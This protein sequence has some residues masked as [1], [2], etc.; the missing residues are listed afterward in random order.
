MVSCSMGSK[1]CRLQFSER[2]KGTGTHTCVIVAET[3]PD[4]LCSRFVLIGRALEWLFEALRSSHTFHAS[5]ETLSPMHI[6]SKKLSIMRFNFMEALAAASESVLSASIPFLSFSQDGGTLKHF[7]SWGGWRW[8]EVGGVVGCGWR[9]VSLRSNHS[10]PD[11]SR[12]ILRR[13]KNRAS[14]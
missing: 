3:T 9:L 10:R 14:I 8:L 5:T 1:D 4:S 2:V 7:L 13:G 11:G 12:S 6:S